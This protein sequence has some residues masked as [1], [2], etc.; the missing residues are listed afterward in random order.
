M[1]AIG[2]MDHVA[3][4][5]GLVWEQSA[6]INMRCGLDNCLEVESQRQPWRRE[7]QHRETQGDRQRQTETET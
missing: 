7:W 1:D 5:A 4:V 2:Q 3:E 6:E